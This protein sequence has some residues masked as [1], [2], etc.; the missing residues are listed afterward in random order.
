MSESIRYEV[1]LLLLSFMTGAGL[2][3]IYDCLRVFRILCPHRPLLCGI[4]DML[5]WIY[6]AWM[7]FSLLYRENDGDIRA[8]VVMAAFAGMV[9][10]Q[11]L[12]SRNFLKYLKKTVKYLRIRISRK[13]C[14]KGW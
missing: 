13:K 11:Y 4:E 14:R 3:M 9:L 6:A 8:Y 2:M 12:I 10:Y 5:Y 7:T 1:R